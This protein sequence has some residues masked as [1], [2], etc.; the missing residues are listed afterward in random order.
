MDKKSKPMTYSEKH[1]QCKKEAKVT[2]IFYAICFAWWM[3]TGWGLGL[4]GNNVFIMGIPLWFWLSVFG[5]LA[6]AFVGTVII[7]RKYFVNFDLG[8]DDAERIESVVSLEDMQED[9]GGEKA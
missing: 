5:L 3:I 9:E 1:E 8:E 2:L 6:I 7:V 4:G